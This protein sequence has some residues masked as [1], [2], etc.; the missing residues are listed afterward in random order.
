MVSSHGRSYAWELWVRQA[1]FAAGGLGGSACRWHFSLPVSCRRRQY[2]FWLLLF[3]GP[4]HTF[5]REKRVVGRS[6]L[7]SGS[8]S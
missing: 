3:S 7:Q 5:S 8:L 6:P 1:F 4:D 2:P